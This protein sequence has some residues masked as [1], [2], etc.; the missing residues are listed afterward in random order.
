VIYDDVVAV[1]S[2]AP[3]GVVDT[4]RNFLC[5]GKLVG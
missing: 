4:R 3:H 2:R 5:Q 1:N